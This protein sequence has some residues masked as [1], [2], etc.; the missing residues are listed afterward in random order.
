MNRRQFIGRTA[1]L[2]LAGGAGTQ[3]L[4]G[5]A[6]ARSRRRRQRKP[7]GARPNILVIT[8]DQQHAGAM[9][10][11]GNPH[12]RT[13]AMDRIASGG[14]RFERAY[15]SNPICVPSRTSYMTGTMPH[16]NGVTYNTEQIPF[17]TDR[18]PCLAQVFRAAGYDTG[19][20]GKWHIPADIRDRDWSGFNTLG[21]VRNNAVDFDIVAP[22][23]EFVRRRRSGPFLA[24]AS[25]VNPHDI[26]EYARILSGMP[27][28]LKN[29][30]IGQPPALAGLPPLARNWAAP[31][32]E[33]QAIR[34]LYHHPEA[35]GTY[36]S[37]TWNGPGDP[38]W[39]QYLW[40]YYRMT[41][42]VDQHI[43]ELLDGLAAAGLADNT[44]ILF[45]S[46]HGDGMASHQWNQKTLF[47]DSCSR[48]PFM[49]QWPGRLPAGTVAKAPL[50][51]LGLDLFP[52]LF[53]AAALTAPAHLQGLSALSAASRRPGAT[54][55][56][57]V[58]SQNNLQPRYGQQ[59]PVNGRM[60]RSCRFK[61]VRYSEGANPEQLFDMDGDP[62]E[63]RSLVHDPAFREVL[64][65][66][67][68]QLGDW[69]RKNADPFAAALPQLSGI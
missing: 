8:T 26:C 44:L 68:K 43:G 6:I 38:R 21:A 40:G 27:D 24:F 4:A 32:N 14:V 52:T 17:D 19:H 28:R 18:F 20:F 62:L 9:G 11:C 36:P 35:L 1:A 31:E 45:T 66:H 47:Y 41:E 56:P 15:C 49:I 54:R 65:D 64:V 29:G 57:F 61:Y 10:C 58:V 50:V 2:A 12:L 39:R 13:P 53:D 67:R 25:F 22:C 55:H 34:D 42:L 48:V 37:R 3:A 59:G 23:L 33:P 60:L 69:M 51:N 7:V 46:D 63:T 5:P 30:P 16:E